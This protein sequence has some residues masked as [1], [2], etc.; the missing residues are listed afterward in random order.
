MPPT[1]GAAMRFMISEPD[2]VDQKIGIKPMLMVA[3]VM[4]LGR[5][6]LAAPSTIAS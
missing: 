3:K 1:M 5:S 4:N 2:P 6:R